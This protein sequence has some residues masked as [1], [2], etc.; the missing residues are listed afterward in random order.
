[1]FRIWLINYI[2]LSRD[3]QEADLLLVMKEENVAKFLQLFDGATE[4][5]SITQESLKTWMVILY[6]QDW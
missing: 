4:T 5:K 2:S 1:M 3:I 6:F